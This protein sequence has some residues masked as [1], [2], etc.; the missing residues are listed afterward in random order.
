MHDV[1]ICHASEDKDEIARPLANRLAEAKLD[2]W[3]DEFSLKLGD[4]LRASIDKGLSNS[5][6]GVVIISPNFFRKKWPQTELNGLFAKEML[7]DKTIIPIWHD[8]TQAEIIKH[9]PILA[10]R[11]AAQ[12]SDGLDV[13][14]E[15]LLDVIEPGS[16]H[17]VSHGHAIAVSPTSFR[18]H[19]G[20]WEIQTPVTILN[21]GNLPAYAVTVR[22]LI[23]G[24]PQVTGGS[25]GIEAGSSDPPLEFSMG[26]VV[27]SA[28][29]LRLN[30]TDDEGKHLVLYIIHTIPAN[31]SRT[32]II[33]GTVP[34]NS[35]AEVSIS[36]V[37]SEPQEL[38]TRQGQGVAI[39][40]TPTERVRLNGAV[41][42]V[43]RSE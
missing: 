40:F 29:Q 38:L 32:I 39:T 25:L 26:N 2:I 42:K 18:L 24:P 1:F 7:G 6:F 14:M 17:K 9:S 16:R 19:S 34:V 8:I 31:G 30:C 35:T 22:V 11:I 5:R 4:S 37:Y 3:F 21:R 27:V 12:T 33:K 10:D 13:V 36:S 23:Q 20:D 15:Q 28:D 41:I 43:K